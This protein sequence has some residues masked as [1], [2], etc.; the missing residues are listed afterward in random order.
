[1]PLSV[2]ACRVAR[3]RTMLARKKCPCGKEPSVKGLSTGKRGWMCPLKSDIQ[4]FPTVCQVRHSASG[5][6]FVLQVDE[7]NSYVATE[8]SQ[9]THLRLGEKWERNLLHANERES[10]S[11]VRHVSHFSYSI[12]FTI[13][14]SKHRL[15]KVEQK[16][17]C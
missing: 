16:C 4:Y 7:K 6:I 3:E 15:Y 2:R 1:M 13:V 5:M 9:R 12:S 14:S 8:H 11:S 10:V 17:Y